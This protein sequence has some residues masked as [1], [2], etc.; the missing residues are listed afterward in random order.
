MDHKTLKISDILK[1]K[2]FSIT[3]ILQL[4]PDGEWLAYVVK[5]PNRKPSSQQEITEFS[6]S[7][8]TGAPVHAYCSEIWVTNIRT[9]ESYRLGSEVG[10]DWAPRW[11]PDGRYLAFCS[12]RMGAPQLWVWDRIENKQRRISDKPICPIDDFEA[13]QWTSDGKQL[14]SRLRPDDMDTS[15]IISTDSNGQAINVW[16]TE[17]DEQFSSEDKL[18]PVAYLKADL[19]VFNFETGDVSILMRGLYSLDM[20]L[21]PNNTTVAVMNLT[22]PEKLTSQTTLFE[23]LLVPLD[24]TPIRRLATKIRHGARVVSWALDGEQLVYAAHPDGL[25]L[26]STQNEEQKNLTANIAENPRF[27]T[28]PLWSTSGDTIFCGFDENVWEL[29]ADGSGARKLTEGLN[30]YIVGIIAKVGTHT[31]W[32]SSEERSI[33]IQTHDRE[34]KK[35]GF[36]MLN[37]AEASA[38]C[39]FEEPI[40]LYHPW[41]ILE[42]FEVVGDGT[43]IIYRSE[44]TT[45]PEEI[46]TF[47]IATGKRRQVTELNPHLYNLDFGEIRIIKSETVEDQCFR[48]VLML[49]ANYEAGKCYPLIAWV[50]PG[51]S[52]SSFAYCF[53]FQ[54]RTEINFQLLAAQG[55]AVLGVDMPLES[56]ESLKDMS[57][58]VLSVV[59][60][61]IEMGI[62]DPNRLGLMGF[63]Y[64]GYSTAG[65][66]TQTTRFK[67]AA[68]GGGLY[69]LTSFYGQLSKQGHSSRIG[70]AE[71]GQGRMGGSL[72]EQRQRYI[73]NSPI[74]HLDKI[75]TPLFI[76]CGDGF[77]GADYAQSGE[78]FSGLRR[79]NK[80]ATFA[81]YRGEGHH[82]FGWRLECQTDCWERILD[83]F[84]KHL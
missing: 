83:W 43:Q 45:G 82:P 50:Y 15:T 8:S 70:W 10:V 33:C 12:D 19:A 22:G 41:S 21:S 25:F 60:E 31:V 84:E 80:K 48:H 32:Q 68:C 34:S 14:I 40:H 5:D 79:L 42:D 46:W 20:S 36:Y 63:S 17:T 49:P 18:N 3:S 78:L 53:G 54:K 29:A 13:P 51:E 27:F 4:S 75:E 61:V 55:F 73:D 47:D 65:V 28:R 2:S 38:T 77:E 35:D 59:D 7:L 30:R 81:W 26:A 56:N 6:G 58:F 76:Y 1:M 69:N 71:E 37:T 24:G 23:L 64:G 16:Q 39:L 52:L 66:I 9:N 74:F 57:E 72:W 44:D 62:A 67:V 11:S